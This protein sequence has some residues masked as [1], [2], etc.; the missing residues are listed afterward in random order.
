MLFLSE[1]LVLIE[2]GHKNLKLCKSVVG[3]INN[4]SHRTVVTPAGL[5]RLRLL[6]QIATQFVEQ[7]FESNPP[8]LPYKKARYKPGF[9]VLRVTVTCGRWGRLFPVH[10]SWRYGSIAAP[11][12]QDSGP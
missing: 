8:E 12:I 3:G 6:V 2:S 1:L 5:R 11:C 9:F 10:Y 4:Y 7:G